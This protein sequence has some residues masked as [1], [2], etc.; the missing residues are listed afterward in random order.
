MKGLL[1]K[2]FYMALKY[3]RVFLFVSV[4]CIVMSFLDSDNLFLAFYSCMLCG[5]IPV[6][7]LA[8]DER[9]RWLQYSETM[10]YSRAEI[11]SAKYL[12]G[13]IAQ[14]T[15]LL[16]N[17]VGFAVRLISA[18]TFDLGVFITVILLM[19]II[20]LISSSFPLPFIFKF[21]VE[22]G[23]IAYYIIVGIASAGSVISSNLLT[24]GVPQNINLNAI[25]AAVCV[26][27]I[28]LYALSWYLSIIFYKNREL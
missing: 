27:G 8:Y 25:L 13:L 5:M 24:T 3:C 17:S 15:V 22:K 23:R 12:I 16:V 2:D 14:T 18:G 19:L 28:G 10:P 20:S 21:G 26:G 9:S 7:L 1:L 11:V 6:S 4:F